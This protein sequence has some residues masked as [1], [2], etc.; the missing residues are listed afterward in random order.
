MLGCLQAVHL[1]TVALTAWILP[2]TT[3]AATTNNNNDE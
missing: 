3:A 2:I 1:L